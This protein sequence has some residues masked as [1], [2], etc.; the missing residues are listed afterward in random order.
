MK[1]TIQI[2]RY[3]GEIDWSDK[4]VEGLNLL[5]SPTG[6]GKTTAMMA[7]AKDHNIGFVAPYVSVTH[8]V[9]KQ[10]D[11]GIKVGL[12][13]EDFV[14]T[15][16]AMIT[17]YHSIPR[18][19]EKEKMDYLF[20]DELHVLSGFAGFIADSVINTFWDTV[21]KLQ[22]KHP[23]LKVVCMTATPHFVRLHPAFDF[24]QEFYI[25]TIEPLSKPKQ[26]QTVRSTKNLL[27]SLPSY[28]YLYPSRDMGYKQSRKY[29]GSY[30]ESSK[31]EKSPVY[32][33]I[34]VGEKPSCSKIFTS[35]CLATGLS[36]TNSGI[37]YAITNWLTLTDIVQ[38][39][40]RIREG[41]DILYVGKCIP[42]FLRGGM[43]KP[44]LT[45]KGSFAAAMREINQ[46]ETWVSLQLHGDYFDELMHD[47]V[48]Q[49]IHL[50]EREIDF[51]N[52][53]Y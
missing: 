8:Q 44:Q 16:Q 18:M 32:Q 39:S 34:L 41:V 43:D 50:P 40:A 21:K 23:G 7:F 28:L 3:C 14:D 47:V 35:T 31:K 46:F 51:N 37:K 53:F 48:Y 42:F 26:I 2:K 12:K 25:T 36:I 10:Y 5:V 6:S 38:T 4:F 24:K 13:T 27:A 11:I 17:S 20:I 30:I 33:E 1:K 29:S 19:L 52:L 45:G 15:S 9:G 49:M 22:A